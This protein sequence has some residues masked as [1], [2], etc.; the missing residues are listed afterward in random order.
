MNTIGRIIS[1]LKQVSHKELLVHAVCISAILIALVW[2]FDGFTKGDEPMRSGVHEMEKI[3]MPVHAKPL[4]ENRVANADDAVRG[5][6]RSASILAEVYKYTNGGSYAGL[7]EASEDM[8]TLEGNSGGI[9]KFIKMVG[10][11]EVFC[12]TGHSEYLIEAKL[13]TS[14]MFFCIDGEGN[15]VEQNESK[16]GSSRCILHAS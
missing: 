3:D 16:E 7:C 5:Y 1:S 8:Y 15:A 10:A 2:V 6:L 9:L 13:P 4:Q 12:M 11:T 14:G